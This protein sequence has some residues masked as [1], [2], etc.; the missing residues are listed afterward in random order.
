M[1]TI[2]TISVVFLVVGCNNS[3]ELNQ[4]EKEEYLALGDNISNNAQTVLLSNVGKQIKENGIAGAVEF[5]SEKSI[6]LTDSLSN[7]K[8]KIQRLSDKS[9]NPENSLQSETDKKAWEE[10]K[11]NP[12]NKPIYG[13]AMG[14]LLF[15]LFK[16]QQKKSKT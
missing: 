16:P 15:S 7:G 12:E 13:S 10:L 9:R 14:G 8:M 4:S 5:C 6:F 1:K 11:N 2:F 3:K